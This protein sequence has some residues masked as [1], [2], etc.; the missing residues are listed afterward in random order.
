M[1]DLGD[2][3]CNACA[4]KGDDAR[5]MCADVVAGVTECT[6]FVGSCHRCG[7][8]VSAT[9]LAELSR[10]VRSTSSANGNAGRRGTHA[11]FN[12][13]FFLLSRPPTLKAYNVLPLD[14]LP[15]VDQTPAVG[16]PHGI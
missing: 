3:G 4:L 14:Q 7:R 15:S 2:G 11:G 16:P 10:C 8:E 1:A 6:E 9:D 5:E 13:F 12:F